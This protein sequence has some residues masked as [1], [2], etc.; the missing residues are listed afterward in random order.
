MRSGAENRIRR[1]RAVRIKVEP[2]VLKLLLASFT[3]PEYDSVLSFSGSSLRA[4]PS[5]GTGATMLFRLL[6]V[7]PMLLLPGCVHRRVTILS[8]PPGAL[9]KVDGKVIGYTPASFDYTWYGEREIELLKDGY[10][11]QRQLIKFSAPWYQR[12]PFEFLSDNFAGGRLQDRR[13][14]RIGMQRRRR[15][16]SAD[17]LQRARSLRSEANHGL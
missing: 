2:D 9:A 13:Q 17:V 1:V 8:D 16:S 5:V 14:V 7:I 10:E 3:D 15:D 4:V 6:P 11:T 12:F